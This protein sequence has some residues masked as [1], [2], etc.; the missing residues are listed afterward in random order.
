MSRDLEH[1]NRYAAEELTISSNYSEE[2]MLL[3]LDSHSDST[4]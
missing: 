2:K 4:D 3:P 1:K